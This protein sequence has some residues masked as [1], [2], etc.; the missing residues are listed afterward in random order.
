MKEFG[1]SVAIGGTALSFLI[2]EYN[3]CLVLLSVLMFLD[4]LTGILKSIYVGNGLRSKTM[5]KGFLKKIGYFIAVIIANFIDVLMLN[6]EPIMRN[7]VCYFYIALEMLSIIENLGL[8][9]IPIPKKLK[10]IIEQLKNDNDD[11]KKE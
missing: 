10:N 8:M 2:G 9:G 1:I 6:N 3:I 11:D 4:I 5:G 7:L